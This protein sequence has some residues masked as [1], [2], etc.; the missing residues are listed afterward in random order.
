MV[1]LCQKELEA[2]C[3]EP[4]YTNRKMNE[5]F[6]RSLSQVNNEDSEN[7]SKNAKKDRKQKSL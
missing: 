7:K 3:I 6:G 4:L 5:F 2:K 1:L